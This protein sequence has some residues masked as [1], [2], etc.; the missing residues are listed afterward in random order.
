MDVVTASRDFCSMRSFPLLDLKR[1]FLLRQL[2][3]CEE[4]LQSQLDEIS[5]LKRNKVHADEEVA[6]LKSNLQS[7]ADDLGHVSNTELREVT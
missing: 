6:T 7:T 1:R 5:S 4:N 2:T 3:K